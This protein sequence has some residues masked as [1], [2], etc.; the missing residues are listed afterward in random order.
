M[1]PLQQTHQDDHLPGNLRK[2]GLSPDDKDSSHGQA[3][4]KVDPLSKRSSK[5][6][7]AS[8]L[9]FV[10]PMDTQTKVHSGLFSH[11][12][13]NIK[14]NL[15][16]VKQRQE[17]LLKFAE[18]ACPNSDSCQRVPEMDE[19]GLDEY[20]L[21]SWIFDKSSPV[22]GVDKLFAVINVFKNS[23]E[24]LTLRQNVLYEHVSC[25]CNTHNECNAN[26]KPILEVMFSNNAYVSGELVNS[27]VSGSKGSTASLFLHYLANLINKLPSISGWIGSHLNFFNPLS[28][29]LGSNIIGGALNHFVKPGGSGASGG[30]GGGF[31]SNILGGHKPSTSSG[32]TN[33]G[34]PGSVTIGVGGGGYAGLGSGSI[35]GAGGYGGSSGSGGYGGAGGSAGVGGGGSVSG[36]LSGV[37]GTTGVGGG[38]A[39]GISV[40]SGGV[41]SAGVSAGGIG[42]GGA[43]GIYG[44]SGGFGGSS[45]F[46]GIGGTG[47]NTGIGGGAGGIFGVPGG[48][49]GSSGFGGFGG[50]GLSA[51]LGGGT[52]GSFNGAGGVGGFGGSS[53]F[54]GFGGGGGS[55]GVGGGNF[56]GNGGFG[57]SSG[58]GGFGGVGGGF[59]GIGGFGG[60]LGGTGGLVG[61]AGSLGG[62][63]AASQGS[64]SS[65]GIGNIGGSGG[66]GVTFGGGNG[67]GTS[68]SSGTSSIS[69]PGSG[70]AAGL[71]FPKPGGSSGFTSSMEGYPSSPSESSE[72]ENSEHVSSGGS[73]YTSLGGDS[74][75]PTSGHHTVN[76]PGGGTTHVSYS[77]DGSSVSVSSSSEDK[78]DRP[79]RQTVMGLETAVQAAAAGQALGY[80]AAL[81]AYHAATQPIAYAAAATQQG[82]NSIG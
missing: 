79:K 29:I 3:L 8:F 47:I 50:A 4:N 37:G 21:F 62:G 17:V 76:N 69:K 36:G 44:G 57:G 28:S 7:W 55:V 45:G 12:A 35:G 68:W 74:S 46:G 73:V 48:F 40:G 49:G 31:W 75:K 38:G 41:G 11:V 32:M 56:G 58:L 18:T 16:L 30:G 53:G 39:G 67:G 72:S 42:G 15:D 80:S 23:V 63:T 43:G 26:I 65:G 9:P 24:K 52:G 34:H 13:E 81:A 19:D 22:V 5:Q 64:V 25:S 14:A 6:S 1:L 61:S 10:N 59:G 71:V 78:I 33:H 66:G 51:G 77:T 2:D 20:R 27:L 54:G 60:G 70:S 82:L